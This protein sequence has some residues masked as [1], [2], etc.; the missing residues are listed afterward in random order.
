MEGYNFPWSNMHELNLDWLLREVKNIQITQQDVEDIRDMYA[1]FSPYLFPTVKT[2][3]AVGDGATDDTQAI[4]DCIMNESIV[5][6]PPG[7]Y[8][9]DSQLEFSSIK[10]KYLV[11]WPHAELDVAAFR[12]GFSYCENIVVDHLTFTGSHNGNPSTTTTLTF[13]YCKNVIVKNSRFLNALNVGLQ[14]SN[15]GQVWVENC[16]VAYAKGSCGIS[17]STD[18]MSESSQYGMLSNRYVFGCW[19]HHNGLDGIIADAHNVTISNCILNDNGTRIN[20]GGVYAQAHHHLRI[21]DTICNNNSGNGIDLDNC[22]DVRVMQCTCSRNLSAGIMF[23]ACRGSTIRDCYCSANGASPQYDGYA[24]QEG[25]IALIRKLINGVNVSCDNIAIS[26]CT[27]DSNAQYGIRLY[28]TNDC[29]ID[30]LVCQSNG[31]AKMYL[32]GYWKE[33]DY[34]NVFTPMT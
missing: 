29:C 34:T 33:S 2:Y 1:Q 15:C 27:L 32:E 14:F 8:K 21:I 23:A 13:Y 3:G 24:Y 10:D 17:F 31:T 28:Q 30:N 5:I 20:A 16:E 22:A 26:G 18:A 7:T 19:C 11:G 12:P 9:I 25:G 6:F 4:I